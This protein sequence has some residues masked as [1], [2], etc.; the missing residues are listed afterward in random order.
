M[1]AIL[2][3]I[4]ALAVLAVAV[5]PQASAA[6]VFPTTSVIA[7]GG[8]YVNVNV[9]SPAPYWGVV[10]YRTEYQNVFVGYDS[11]GRPM[12]SVQPVTVAVHG[13]VYPARTYYAPRYYYP[14]RHSGISFGAG[15]RFRL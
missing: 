3:S 1:K 6:P 2:A 5:A 15:I 11:Y 12:Y 14:R 10:G 13:W 8:G 9:G 4:L 7:H